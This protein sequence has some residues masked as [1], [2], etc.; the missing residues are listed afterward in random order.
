M[1]KVMAM[2]DGK[3]IDLVQ[4][5]MNANAAIFVSAMIRGGIDAVVED[6]SGRTV[7]QALTGF[8]TE[9][10]GCQELG[11]A[12]W[13]ALESGKKLEMRDIMYIIRQNQSNNIEDG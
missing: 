12:F 7:K 5:Y 1:G 10:C 4:S 9:I 11:E 2:V 8:F 3:T 13:R 6:G